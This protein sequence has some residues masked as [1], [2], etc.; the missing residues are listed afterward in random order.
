MLRVVVNML[1][2]Y[3]LKH[4]DAVLMIIDIQEKLV[5]TMKYGHEVIKSTNVLIET[6]ETFD[7]PI[8]ITEQYTKGLG[9]TVEN[10]NLAPEKSNYFEKMAFCG[11]TPE[12]EDF[13]RST[14]R[15]SIIITGMET[16]ICVYQTVRDL[17]MKGYHVYVARDGVCSRT[18]AN[19]KNGL[20]LMAEMGAVVSNTET[21]MFDLLK[22]SGTPEF[23]KLSKLIK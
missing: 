11:L 8:V 23:K 6:A 21:L 5:P 18:K 12:V 15:K 17:L 22:V 3:N 13:L 9:K 1:T 10:L 20:A 14:H 7:M 19:F 2:K 4:E 16:H